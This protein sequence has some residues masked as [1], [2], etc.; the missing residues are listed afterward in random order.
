[1]GSQDGI[2][3]HRLF[4]RLL[5][6]K[7]DHP[8]DVGSILAE[9]AKIGPLDHCRDH[10]M[11]QLTKIVPTGDLTFR[12]VFEWG[13]TDP[14]TAYWSL[15]GLV[16]VA[17]Q[18][19]YSQLVA[20]ALDASQKIEQRSKAVKELALDSG[21]HFIRGLPSD[22]GRWRGEQLPLRELSQWAAAG[23]PRGPGFERPPRH[24][25]LDNPVSAIDSIAS[26]LDAKLA[27]SRQERQDIA[28][29]SNWL[30]PAS[31]ADISAAQALWPLPDV[32]VE[33]LSKFS[34]LRVAVESR[35][36]YQGL[37]LYGAAELIARQQGYSRNPLTQSVLAGW[38]LGYV[39]IA[40]HAADPFVLDLSNRP[41]TDA[42]ILTALHGTGVWE[43]RKEAPSFL[44]F[45]QRLAH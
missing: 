4:A 18:T 8:K 7:N 33:F 34:P 16:R 44:R 37:C 21:Q 3:T 30:T 45:L 25:K 19:S 31:A 14:N 23:F 36:H 39:V 28:N 15:E 29:P 17:G 2:E 12:S 32:Y 20:F 9:Y 42:P 41:V 1:M 38:P 13:L 6:A 22:P 27:K 24:P 43:F 35:R 26:R 40:D 11:A 10:A 5:R